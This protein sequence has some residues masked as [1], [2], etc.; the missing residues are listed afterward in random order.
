M[1]PYDELLQQAE[2]LG[3]TLPGDSS[4]AVQP[5]KD[6]LDLVKQS[7]LANGLQL[8]LGTLTGFVSSKAF[9]DK[10][11]LQDRVKW[12][13]TNAETLHTICS[14]KDSLADRL[15]SAKMRPSVPVAPDY[16]QD[17]SELLQHSA[18]S[19][20][21]L[22]DGVAALQWAASLDAKP[23]VWEDQLKC[24]LEVAKEVSGCLTA[25]EEFSAALVSGDSSSGAAAVQHSTGDRNIQ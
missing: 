23:S 18:S 16:Q 12:M 20:G 9:T 1:G 14:T 17:F 7:Q 8:Q 6:T 10:Q 5:L 25:M 24:I 19:A 21:M 2:S 15:R 22:H 3:F 11:A 4:D 13:S